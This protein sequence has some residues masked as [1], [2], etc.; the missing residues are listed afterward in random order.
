MGGRLNI[1]RDKYNRYTC[2]LR[3]CRYFT[4]KFLIQGHPQSA[5][6]PHIVDFKSANISFIIGPRGLQCQTNL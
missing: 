4:L 1:I 3:P 6:V 5:K 2:P